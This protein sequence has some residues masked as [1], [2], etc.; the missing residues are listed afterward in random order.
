[1]LGLCQWASHF[2]SPERFPS[3]VKS[4]MLSWSALVSSRTLAGALP[5]LVEDMAG[6]AVRSSSTITR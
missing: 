3:I 1:M 6:A 5:R 4:R 2:G